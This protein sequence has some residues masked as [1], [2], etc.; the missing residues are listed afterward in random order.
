M[1]VS[2]NILKT[3]VQCGSDIGKVCERLTETGS[4]VESVTRPGKKLSGVR[5]GKIR[6]IKAHPAKSSLFVAKLDLGGEDA[7]CVTAATNLSNGD[8]VA[9]AAPG[10]TISDG[11]KMGIRDFDGVESF[12]MMLSAEELGVPEIG[13]EFGILRL[14]ADAPLGANAVSYLGLDDVILD[15]SITPNRGD[16]LSHVGVARELYAL[17]DDAVF[18][19]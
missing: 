19:G 4:E 8:V 14:P 6:E 18:T 7:H 10:A 13:L 9:Y 17:F 5:I 3:L 15:L 16:L 12:G 1:L 11:T 2:W